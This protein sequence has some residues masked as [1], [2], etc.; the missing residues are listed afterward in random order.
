MKAT[1]KHTHTHESTQ[2]LRNWIQ[3]EKHN[4]RL[5]KVNYYV[6]LN[7]RLWHLFFFI[8][9]SIYPCWI[10][11]I[12]THINGLVRYNKTKRKPQQHNCERNNDGLLPYI[13]IQRMNNQ[14]IF[15]LQKDLKCDK[16]ITRFPSLFEETLRDRHLHIWRER[17]RKKTKWITDIAYNTLKQTNSC[18]FVYLTICESMFKS[19]TNYIYVL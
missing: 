10:I 7:W 13:C 17:E 5:Y 2:M 3:R 8:F 15:F 14:R 6:N 4:Y 18:L 1:S 19:K 12:Y 11:H 9:F 16:K